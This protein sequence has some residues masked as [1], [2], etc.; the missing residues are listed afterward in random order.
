MQENMREIDSGITLQKLEIFCCVAELG[1]VT[2][3]A[4][5]I[6]IAQPVVTAHIRS[7]E[8]KLGV[9]LVGRAG[10]NISLTEAGQRVFSWAAEVIASKRQLEREIGT[11]RVGTA[12]NVSVA[13]SI[14][15]GSYILPEIVIAFHSS[16]PEA[17]ISTH[18]SNSPAA[19]EAVRTGEC[20]FGLMTTEGDVS[21]NL[22]VEL[23]WNE[24][25]VLVASPLNRHIGKGV[26]IH[27]LAKLPFITG[28]K[29]IVRRTIEDK[30][31]AE[32]GVNRQN[33]VL[34]LSHT[35]SIKRAVRSDVGVSFLFQAALKD[36]LATGMLNRVEIPGLQMFVP[37]I[38][39]YRRDRSFTALQ[40]ALIDRVRAYASPTSADDKLPSKPPTPNLAVVKKGP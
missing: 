36:E 38:L 13:A 9:R 5:R 2:K 14:T 32:L 26:N 30:N 27:D 35:E 19:C 3:A 37:V 4:E 31:L 20:D 11:L 40:Q 17:I 15:V 34:E 8:A 22:V 33:I 25:L 7:L 23:L 6:G 39:V 28:P 18:V 12:A 24:P 29:S 21:E 10:R 1:S 16:H